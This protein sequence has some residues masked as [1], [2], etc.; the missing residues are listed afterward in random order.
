MTLLGMRELAYNCRSVEC[1]RG[2]QV[3]LNEK[4]L[5][6]LFEMEYARI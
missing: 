1:C 2:E 4:E 6:C 3:E 5:A